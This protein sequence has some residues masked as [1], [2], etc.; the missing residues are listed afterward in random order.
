MKAKHAIQTTLLAGLLAACGGGGGGSDT[1]TLS[2]QFIDAPVE[3][4]YYISSTGVTGTTDADGTFKFKAGDS[5]IFRVGGSDGLELV[6]VTPTPAENTQIK[7]SD[8]TEAE[9]AS[10][11][12]QILQTFGCDATADCS[13]TKLDLKSIKFTAEQKA[14]LQNHIKNKGNVDDFAN[15]TLTN[16]ATAVGTASGKTFKAKTKDEVNEHI[17]K[18]NAK[19]PTTSIPSFTLA[20]LVDIDN[21]STGFMGLNRTTKTVSSLDDTFTFITGTYTQS[22]AKQIDTVWKTYEN[23]VTETKGDIGSGCTSSIAFDRVLTTAESSVDGFRLNFTDSAKCNDDGKENKSVVAA[24]PLDESFNINDLSGKKLSIKGTKHLN[25]TQCDQ[26][27]EI[28]FSTATNGALNINKVA[29]TSAFTNSSSCGDIL[30]H[31]FGS[32][33]FGSGEEKLKPS[34]KSDAI[35]TIDFGLRSDVPNGY[36]QLW[37]VKSK[38]IDPKLLLIWVSNIDWAKTIETSSPVLIDYQFGFPQAVTYKISSIN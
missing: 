30:Y 8:L 18:A 2:G 32:N 33:N 1:T 16:M 6:S 19:F 9:G 24:I 29:P 14:T 25:G 12:A 28:E 38:G 4:L 5:V 20:L 35:L 23:G 26:F 17:I 37:I 36:E 10:Q 27:I 34:S 11:I 3:G 31:G 15:A 22:S 13:T 7:V 21:Y